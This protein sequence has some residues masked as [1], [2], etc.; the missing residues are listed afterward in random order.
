MGLQVNNEKSTIYHTDTN[1][2]V[3]AWLSELFGINAQSISCGIK[4]L[5]FQIKA[6]GYSKNDWKWI[7]DRFYKRISAWEFRCLS[8]AG[9]VILVQSVLNQLAIY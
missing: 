5:G 2:E 3:V 1:Q 9:R 7:L 8:L 4:C 6:N